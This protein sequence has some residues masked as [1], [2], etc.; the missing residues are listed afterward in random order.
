MDPNA[1]PTNQRKVLVRSANLHINNGTNTAP[2]VS[3]SL[4]DDDGGGGDDEESERLCLHSNR[5][6]SLLPFQRNDDA[7]M[8]ADMPTIEL[9]NTGSDGDMRVAA[10]R[11][12]H[13]RIS[14]DPALRNESTWKPR[15]CS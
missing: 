9:G 14:T 1:A 13:N 5:S 11:N 4:D 7:E 8:T 10:A 12:T 6:E 15:G 2:I 3:P